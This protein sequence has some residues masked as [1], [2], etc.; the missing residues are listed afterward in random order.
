M[1]VPQP[2]DGEP[3]CTY[4]MTL[5]RDDLQIAVGECVYIMRDYKQ[6]AKGVP[7]RTSYRLMSTTNPE[8]LD[9][10]RIEELWMNKEYV[11]FHDAP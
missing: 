5:M 4:Y 7:V 6:S 8:K 10:F 11:V 1:L 9:I 3:D 2:D